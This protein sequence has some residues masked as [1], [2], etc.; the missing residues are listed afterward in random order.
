MIRHILTV[1]TGTLTSRI[2][3]FLRDSLIAAL[4]HDIDI[5]RP[6]VPRSNDAASQVADDETAPPNDSGLAAPKQQVATEIAP[7]DASLATPSSGT[8]WTND[9]ER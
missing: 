5:H 7:T 3:G 8:S 6:S 2:L 9:P 4:V 1:S